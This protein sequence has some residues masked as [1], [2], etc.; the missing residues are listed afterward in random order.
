MENIIVY[1][2]AVFKS[3]LVKIVDGENI[4]VFLGFLKL[5]DNTV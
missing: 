3:C 4:F 2:I 5:I 1:Q